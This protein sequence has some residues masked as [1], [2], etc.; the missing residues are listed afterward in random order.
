MDAIK[1]EKAAKAYDK[2]FRALP[3]IGV[4]EILNAFGFDSRIIK[5]GDAT[6]YTRKVNSGMMNPYKP[7][8]T[9]KDSKVLTEYLECVLKPKRTYAEI[10]DNLTNYDDKDVEL[11]GGAEKGKDKHPMEYEIISSI[12]EIWTRDLAFALLHGERSD[13]GKGPKASFDGILTRIAA[14][15]VSEQISAANKNMAT[16]GAIVTPIEAAPLA[17]LEQLEGF[18]GGADPLM[19]RG[20]LLLSIS[21]GSLNN[22]KASYGHKVKNFAAN[23]S[24]QLVIDYL[25]DKCRLSNLSFAVNPTYGTGSQLIL[26]TPKTFMFGVKDKID[27]QFV[28]VRT[29]YPDPNDVQFFVQ[30]AYD[31]AIRCVDKTQFLTNEQVNTAPGEW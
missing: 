14:L 2:A 7:G 15:K 12:L 1:L 31:T 19:R 8:L 3:F 29:P 18:L 26:T 22:V 6:Y 30:D 21:E 25:K 23:I 13:A 17:A 24:D 11:F 4:Q 5:R 28:T 16:T 10:T 27:N 9:M 20:Q